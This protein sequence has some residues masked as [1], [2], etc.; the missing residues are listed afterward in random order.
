MRNVNNDF[1]FHSRPFR[2]TE[3]VC[4][5]VLENQIDRLGIKTLGTAPRAAKIPVGGPDTLVWYQHQRGIVV[6]IIDRSLT[7]IAYCIL[8]CVYG[9]AWPMQAH[10]T[11]SMLRLKGFLPV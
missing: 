10:I 5:L 2:E 8:H 1:E 3:V 6:T 11:D 4:P 7:Y 9:H